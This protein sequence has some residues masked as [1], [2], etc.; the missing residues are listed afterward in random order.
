MLDREFV[1][2]N[3]STIEEV[4]AIKK[5]RI[6]VDK[7]Y[8]CIEQRKILINEI[9][10]LRE[11][12]NTL[13]KD[14]AEMK[15]K[16]EDADP[17]LEESRAIGDSIKDIEKKLKEI[18]A[19]EY[20]LMS[21]LPN[22]PHE[23]VSTGKDDIFSIIY[24]NGP[25]NATG[26]NY[27]DAVIKN[28]WIDFK[29]GAK[30]SGSNFPLFKGQGAY[31]ERLLI[32][33]MT[34][35]HTVLHGYTEVFTPYLVTGEVLFATGQLPKLADDMYKIDNDNLYLIPTAEPPVTTI[36]MGE[37][38]NEKNLPVKYAAYSACF[39][40]EAGSYGADT[41]GHKRVHQFNKV[42]M[43]RLTHPN[44]SYE[45]LEEMV[46]NARRILD[47]LELNYRV[48]LLPANDMSFASAKT[49]DIEI[50]A[51]GSGEFLEV[52][53]VSNFEDF[54]ARRANIRF[55]DAGGKN[56][57]VHTLNGSGL[58]TPRLLI[59]YMEKYVKDSQIHYPK[60]LKAYIDRG[61][62]ALKDL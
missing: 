28:E 13:S 12:R 7:L 10:V 61:R 35:V 18:E 36:H 33:F 55:K 26:D 38:L 45:A 34:D 1:L 20:E 27:Y 3:R 57:F 6:D 2:N 15:K 30:L 24:E 37:I 29:R 52:S 49:Y 16:G 54:Q 23:S 43:V 8:D 32:N 58:A 31:L 19:Q 25:F 39:R 53:S 5:G 17:L 14:I 21:W 56:R 42:E 47:L 4:L 44:H 51:E 46:M 40:R 59:A 60:A 9:N 50:W 48:I 22:V 11:K 62:A 41:K